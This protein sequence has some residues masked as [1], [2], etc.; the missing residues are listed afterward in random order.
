MVNAFTYCRTSNLLPNSWYNIMYYGMHK[1]GMI[2][3]VPFSENLFIC[4]VLMPI[5]SR[6]RDLAKRFA[7]SFTVID[8]V[9]LF[10]TFFFF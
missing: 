8:S 5:A 4:V 9:R 7:V 1:V 2:A 6:K 3:V 10:F